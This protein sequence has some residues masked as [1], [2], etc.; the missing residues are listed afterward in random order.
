MKKSV[1][2]L[3][4][5]V[6]FT[7]AGFSQI[8]FGPRI[9]FLTSNLT[10]KNVPSLVDDGS[11][12]VGFQAGV[13]A[14]LSL[15][16][17]WYVQPEVLYTASGASLEIV[18]QRFDYDFDRIDVPVLVGTKLGPVRL[19]AGPV[20]RFQLDSKVTLPDGA[21]VFVNNEFND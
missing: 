6:V 9:S 8:D 13:F 5:V 20:V 14:R 10:L 4:L 19:N 1:I 7:Q 18:N 3:L 11:Y 12:Q 2:T 16:S 15:A 21:A 17:K